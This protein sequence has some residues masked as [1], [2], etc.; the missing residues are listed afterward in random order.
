MGLTVVPVARL[1]SLLSAAEIAEPALLKVDVQGHEYEALEGCSG[2]LPAFRQVAVEASFVELYEGQRLAG[3]V[4]ALLEN[5]GFSLAGVFDVKQ[6]SSG[7][8]LQADLLF[9]RRD[10]GQMKI[11]L[12]SMYYDPVPMGIGPVATMLAKQLSARGNDVTVIASHP[13]YPTAEL[14]HLLPAATAD[15]RR[16]RRHRAAGL[17]RN[18]RRAGSGCSARSAT[19]PGRPRP[20]WRRSR[21]TS[22]SSRCPR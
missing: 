22:S 7:Q 16:H 4:T 5:A 14:G 10:P 11:H 18:A 15:P 1:D 21:P 19:A 13:H 2:I 20:R 8:C 12:W 17:H 3:E 6:A 9:A